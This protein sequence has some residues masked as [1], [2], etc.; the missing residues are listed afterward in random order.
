MQ[1]KNNNVTIEKF[2]H[3][4]ALHKL[5][6]TIKYSADLKSEEIDLFAGSPF[7]TEIYEQVREEY[8]IHL[9]N[10]GHGKLADE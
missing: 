4:N 7:I 5:L 1:A 3:L 2:E 10:Q 6:G 8:I 9:R